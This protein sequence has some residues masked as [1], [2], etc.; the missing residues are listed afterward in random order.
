M[1]GKPQRCKFKH[2]QFQLPY[3]QYKT[4]TVRKGQ[5]CAFQIDLTHR[6]AQAGLKQSAEDF[7]SWIM[8]NLKFPVFVVEPK[9]CTITN[10]HWWLASPQMPFSHE[11]LLSALYLSDEKHMFSLF[12][13]TLLVIDSWH[14]L[15]VALLSNDNTAVCGTAAQCSSDYL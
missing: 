15:L 8:R 4:V 7:G 14:H 12:M 9:S 6:S 13:L 10:E 1:Y 3:D 5:K 2:E 11:R